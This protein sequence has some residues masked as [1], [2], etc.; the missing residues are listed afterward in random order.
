[1]CPWISFTR[2]VVGWMIPLQERLRLL[3]Y[4]GDVVVLA[5][6]PHLDLVET[7]QVAE[8]EVGEAPVDQFAGGLH[9]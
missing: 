9:S 3:I 6:L 5:L 2:H 4:F 1:M 8:D 7:A